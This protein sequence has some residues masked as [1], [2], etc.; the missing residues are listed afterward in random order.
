MPRLALSQSQTPC[1]PSSPSTSAPT[2][3]ESTKSDWLFVT[4]NGDPPHQNTVGY[5]F[6][7]AKWTAGVDSVTL[8]DLRHFYASGLIA[9]GWDV[10]TVQRALG[11]AKASTT[12][13]TY[14]HLWPTGE[15]RTRGAVEAL[16]DDTVKAATDSSRT[17]TAI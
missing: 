10:V 4:P 2:R 11:H 1:W 14:A 15:E 5:W 7:R 9:A 17:A 13:N 12:L 8:H 3:P 16:M 6:R